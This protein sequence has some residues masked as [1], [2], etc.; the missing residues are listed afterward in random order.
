MAL[1]KNIILILSLGS[2]ALFTFSANAEI[3]AYRFSKSN[4]A[5]KGKKAAG[6]WKIIN[7]R[8]PKG[9]S[10]FGHP[11]KARDD[12]ILFKLSK[13][14]TLLFATMAS[15]LKKTKTN[16]TANDEEAIEEEITNFS[17]EEEEDDLESESEQSSS[18]NKK[19][20]LWL[21]GASWQEEVLF[22]DG[23]STTA[24]GLANIYG[25]SLGVS[26]LRASKQ[27]KY[28]LSVAAFFGKAFIASSNTIFTAA[29]NLNTLG[30]VSSIDV[31]WS[32]SSQ[33]MIGLSVPIIYRKGKWQASTSST[34]ISPASAMKYGI[35]IESRLF[36]GAFTFAPKIGLINPKNLFGHLQIGY[37]F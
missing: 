17:D 21:G 7:R 37:S 23:V 28:G 36:Y 13:K 35:S 15:C 1:I 33:S 4:C 2:A 8:L 31:F 29:R 25:P 9:L 27:F 12:V 30:L 11:S 6:T 22:S 3:F 10:V 14:S 19:W 20:S 24:P 32:L 26:Y 34:S 18:S 5:L 16:N